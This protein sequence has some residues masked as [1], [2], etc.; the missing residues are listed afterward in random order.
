MNIGEAAALS[1]LPAKTLR[2]YED[3][4]LVRPSG[5]G[6]NN[7]RAY[8]GGDVRRLAFVRRARALGFSVKDC[9]ELL[10]LQ[11]DRRR[12]S[13]DVKGLALAR[14]ADIDRRI[15]ELHAMRDGLKRLADRC[16]GDDRPDCAI[17]DGLSAGRAGNDRALP[18]PEPAGE[19]ARS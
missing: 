15:D 18:A 2:Y 11:D 16:R 4:G 1:G 9:R 12:A 14:V 8:G 6:A 5:R 3:I 13:A 7:Y 17:L 10:D 19:G